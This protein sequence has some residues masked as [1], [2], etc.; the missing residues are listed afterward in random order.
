MKEGEAEREIGTTQKEG[1]LVGKKHAKMCASFDKSQMTRVLFFH[2]PAY[3][4]IFACSGHTTFEA[5]HNMTLTTRTKWAN[6]R[7]VRKPAWHE[8]VVVSSVITSDIIVN[9]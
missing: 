3:A 2:N 1:D 4:S 6:I 8:H 5:S 9:F 7:K